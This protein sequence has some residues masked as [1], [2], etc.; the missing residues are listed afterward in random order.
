MVVPIHREN[1]PY[2][3]VAVDSD[4]GFSWEVRTTDNAIL[5][6]SSYTVAW[7]KTHIR[8]YS[9]HLDTK[10][11]HECFNSNCHRPLIFRELFA[12]NNGIYDLNVGYKAFNMPLYRKLKRLWKS[13][14]VE[15]YC[16]NCF[17]EVN[18]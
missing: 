16:C 18:R 9:N 3:V 10:Y 11:P 14:I 12:A 6:P 1:S 7:V 17:D 2:S 13:Q 8:A 5:I 15:F 4:E